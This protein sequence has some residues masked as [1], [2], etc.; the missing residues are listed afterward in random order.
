MKRRPNLCL[1]LLIGV[2]LLL[3]APLANAA[4]WWR[5]PVWGAEV[6]VFAVDPFAPA[7][8]YCGT[9]RGNFHGSTD[10]GGSWTPLRQGAAFPGYIATG[11]IADPEVPGRVWATLAGQF[12]GGL[13]ARSDDRGANWT[14]L[15]KWKVSV[16]TRALAL[17]PG[18][19]LFPSDVRHRDVPLS[20]QRR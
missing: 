6:R 11:L 9:S 14:V 17:A 7:T 4:G 10:G 3:P 15:S 13:I 16:A 12:Q 20:H 8:L 18:N 2:V 19:P 1:D 5:R